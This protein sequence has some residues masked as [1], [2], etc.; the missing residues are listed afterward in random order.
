MRASS[1]AVVAVRSPR[2]PDAWRPPSLGRRRTPPG[3]RGGQLAWADLERGDVRARARRGA[4]RAHRRQRRVVPLVPRD[5]R[6][7]VQRSEVRKL[8]GERFLP[9]RVDIDARPDFEERYHDWG[10][11][12]TV[13]MTA[14]A[15]EIGKF[16]G[17]M[18][19]EKFLDVLR[20]AAAAPAPAPGAAP[21][22]RDGDA[23]G[24]ARAKSSSRRL[25]SRA[26][27]VS[28]TRSG[29]REEGSWG[30]E[31]KVPLYWDNAWTLAQASAGRA[32]VARKRAL[33]TLDQQ[34]KIID[35]VWGGICQ[36]STDGDWLHPHYEKLTPYQAGAIDNYATAFALTGDAAVARHR[37]ARARLRR[38]LHDEPRGRLL[39][40]DGRRSERP[41]PEQAAGLGPRLLREGRRRAPRARHPSGRRARVRARERAR[42]RLVRHARHGGARC[43]GHRGGRARRGADPR[44][45]RDEP[46]RNRPRRRPTTC[47]CSTSPTTPRSASRSC[48]STRR[49]RDPRYLEA[50]GRSPTSCCASCRT[51]RGGFL[52]STP[53]PTARRRPGRAAQALRGQRDG[54]SLPRRG[55]RASR[56]ATPTGARSGARSRSSAPRRPSTTAVAWS[57]TCS[58]P[59]RR[60]STCG[61]AGRLVA[62]PAAVAARRPASVARVR[63]RP[64]VRQALRSRAALPSPLAP[65]SAAARLGGP[66]RRR[67]ARPVRLAPGGG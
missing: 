55:S 26:Q 61:R 43:D 62:R 49:P 47:A 52:A 20:A 64:R 12:A 18:P 17:Y 24:A 6:D 38:P 35:P 41:R 42:H 30:D 45:A 13:L 67:P 56:R 40:D 37:A 60:P 4:D 23:A 46:R 27:R 32:S 14:N 53:D 54:H 59:S 8:L 3:P 29:T 34:R 22:E 9:V 21:G 15:E 63:R 25:A 2:R 39:R 48:A 36:Y 31:Q 11:P 50:P 10:W 66:R 51:P 16:K 7:D 28:S 5:G 57:A 65:E 44:D 19:P 1:H 33:F 58:S